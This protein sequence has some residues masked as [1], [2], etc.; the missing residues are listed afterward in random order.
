MNTAVDVYQEALAQAARTASPV[1][2]R[3]GGSKSFYGRP[4]DGRP[5]D[6]NAHTGIIDYSP[7]ELVVSARAGTLLSELEA[8]L[9]AENQI[10]PFEPPH[11]GP[12][13]TLGGTIACGLSGP[14]RPYTGAARD[15]VLG[16]TCLNGHGELLRFGGQVMKN[17]AGY[18]LSRTLTGSLGTL[19]LLLEINLKVLPRAEHELTLCRQATGAE[20]I[21]LFNR[22][23]GRPLPLS[24]ACHIDGQLHVRL[25]GFEQGVTAAAGSLGGDILEDGAA[26]WQGLRE[27]RLPFFAGESPLWRISVPPASAP[28]PL[29]GDTLID[30]G[31]A[32]RWIRTDQ[33]AGDVREAAIAAGGHATRFRD[34]DR[35]DVFHPLSHS[36]LALQQRLKAS[37]DPA[38]IL[39]PGRMY[40]GL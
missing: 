2:I 1:V 37:F 21:T 6:V 29:D 32:Q 4:V 3:G 31:G 39:N 11:F 30:W 13:A 22:W 12:A 19:A 14:R 25:S 24:A 28:L 36:M 16:I 9:A 18:D 5:L 10:L 27:Q 7:P 8:T 40:S 17:V 15:F 38:G 33:P 23:A 35:D 34:S 20:A 26:F